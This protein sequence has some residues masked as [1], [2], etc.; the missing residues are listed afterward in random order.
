M[1]QRGQR[2]QRRHAGRITEVKA[3][4]AA[5]C[6]HRV[7]RR[8]AA[9]LDPQI[10]EPFDAAGG[11]EQRLRD[12]RAEPQPTHALQRGQHLHPLLDEFALLA[13]GHVQL[14]AADREVGAAVVLVGRLQVARLVV[15]VQVPVVRHVGRLAL[16]QPAGLGAQFGQRGFQL[17]AHGTPAPA[18]G[19]S[20]SS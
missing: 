3:S 12:A 9:P 14:G 17:Q 18:A 15:L 2:L 13:R 10:R 20:P 11:I 19:A 7:E 6:G 16:R 4:Q 8:D 5:E 1:R